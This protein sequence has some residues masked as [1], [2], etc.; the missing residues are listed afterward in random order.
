MV[1]GADTPAIVYRSTGTGTSRRKVKTRPVRHLGVV[2]DR[3]LSICCACFGY[4]FCLYYFYSFFC[5]CH[6]F[7]SNRSFRSLPGTTARLI[8]DR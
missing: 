7:C 3:A 6:F 8:G 1:D 4:F 5:S 2:S